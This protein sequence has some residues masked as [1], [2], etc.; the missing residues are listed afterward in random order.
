VALSKADNFQ[1]PLG[2]MVAPL[3]YMNV[4]FDLQRP[5]HIWS[6]A[7]LMLLAAACYTATGWL[8]GAALVLCFNFIERRTGAIEASV[9]TDETRQVQVWV[10]PLIGS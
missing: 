7:L 8:T 10:Q 1:L 5:T 2:I 3:C 6:A 9:L 4:N